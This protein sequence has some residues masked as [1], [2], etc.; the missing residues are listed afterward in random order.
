VRLYSYWRSS[1]S[2]RVRIALHLKKLEFETVPVSLV[3]DGGEQRHPAY[4]ARNPQMLVPFLEDGDV[5]I[6]Q[7]MAILE[8]LEE[9]YTGIPLLPAGAA[10]RARVRAFA[11]L[12][13]ADIQP[14]NNLRVL[15]YLD[16]ALGLDKPARDAWYAHWVAT[17]FDALETLARAARNEGPYTYGATPTFADVCLVPQIYNARRFEV[18]L[19]DYPRLVEIDAALNELEAFRQAAPEAQPDRP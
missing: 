9:T 8:Y 2:Y 6:G 10:A 11:L 7:S 5:A 12:V 17:G 15:G 13:T 1:S 14:L 4:R 18:P 16:N 3:A 19:D